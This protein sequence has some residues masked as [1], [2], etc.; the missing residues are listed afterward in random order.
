MR[1]AFVFVGFLTFG[2]IC[3]FVL[4]DS[5]V[6]QA[7]L[8][9]LGPW[10]WLAAVVFLVADILLPIPSTLIMTVLGQRYGP[11]LGG[12]IGTAGSCFAGVVAYALTRALGRRF[13]SWLLGDELEAA[14]R[15]YAGPGGYAVACSRWLPLIPEAVSCMAGLARMPFRKYMIALVA[16]SAPMCFAY[17]SLAVVSDNQTLPLVVSILLPL[18]IWWL[19]A[20]LLKIVLRARSAETSSRAGSS[21]DAV[22][23]K[24]D[25]TS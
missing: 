25:P 9:A 15:F 13:A 11:L 24:T 14:E 10:V 1:T 4:G 18:P 12:L 22:F 23:E 7:W 6:D 2:L 21:R 3:F 16:G 8:D 5:L 17:A 19:A 20:R